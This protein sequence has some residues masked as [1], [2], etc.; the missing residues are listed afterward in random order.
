MEPIN[1]RSNRTYA[2]IT[3]TPPTPRFKNFDDMENG[4]IYAKWSV[5]VRV[6]VKFLPNSYADNI[7]FILMDKNGA[8]IEANVW[9]H[10]EVERFNRILQPGC[11]GFTKYR[12]AIFM[13][14]WRNLI[15]VGIWGCKLIQNSYLWSTSENGNPIV[16]ATMLQKDKEFGN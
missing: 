4:Y 5:C 3:A 2:G 14:T 16:V 9:G 15:P 11:K 13:D 7:T 1:L 6:E 10:A 8:K 12:E